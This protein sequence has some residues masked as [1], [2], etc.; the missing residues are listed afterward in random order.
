M[1]QLS[2]Q[3][4]GDGARLPEDAGA[5][6][7]VATGDEVDRIGTLLGEAVGAYDG[8]GVGTGVASRCR[9]KGSVAVVRPTVVAAS[10]TASF[11]IGQFEV[12]ISR[13]LYPSRS[14]RVLLPEN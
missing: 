12:M 10:N 5:G 2:S 13:S 1:P 3:Q 11:M 9:C 6:V 7:D 8:N 14:V 4:F